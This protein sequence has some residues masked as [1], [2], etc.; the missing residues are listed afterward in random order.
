VREIRAFAAIVRFDVFRELQRGDTLL[1]MGLVGLITLFLFS[2]AIPPTKEVLLDTRAGIL[3]VTF[4]LAGTIG[5]ERSFRRD[6]GALEGLL[7]APIARATLYYARVASSVL[8]I[9]VL[10]AILLAL[11]LVLFNES[12]DGAGL[13]AVGLGGLAATI[14]FAA[15]GVLVAA[16]TG[17]LRGGDV[18]LR[19][20]LFPMLVPV[21]ASAVTLT[22]KAFAG[23][24]VGSEEV[25]VLVAFDLVFLGLGHLLFEHVA[26]DLGPQG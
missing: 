13:I 14:G 16:M 24:P 5:V 23:K 2:F 8:F 7:L 21:F 6:G 18:L 10:E 9:A 26:R 12:L 17:G 11:F 1:S 3:W 22:A 20:L 15:V 4:L 25:G 19:I